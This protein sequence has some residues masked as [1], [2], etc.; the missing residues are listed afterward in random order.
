[1][2]GPLRGLLSSRQVFVGG[3]RSGVL[4]HVLQLLSSSGRVGADVW[5]GDCGDCLDTRV[6]LGCCRPLHAA[7]LCACAQHM[8]VPSPWTPSSAA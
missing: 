7:G 2:L 5:C 6:Q 1:V 3:W 8:H 4:L